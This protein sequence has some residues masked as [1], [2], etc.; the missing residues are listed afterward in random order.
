M[1]S[2]A[3]ERHVLILN[4][5]G[6]RRAIALEAAA[7]SLGRDES[8]AIVL[9]FE[10]VSRQHAILLR[11][12]V[13][14]TTNYRYRLVDGNANGKPST[15]GTFVN[16]KRISSHELHHGDV[17]LFGRKAK[18]SYMMV[19]MAET[20]FSQYLQSIAF[21]SIKSD[22]RGAKE[23]LVGMELSGELRRPPSRELVGAAKTALSIETEPVKPAAKD[24]LAS[25]GGDT[26]SQANK[27][28]VH[29]P[30]SHHGL[31]WMIGLGAIATVVAAIFVGAYLR[32]PA[33]Q[34]PAPT[35]SPSVAQP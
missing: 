26:S 13:P 3:Q 10:T 9:D 22:L 15:N 2:L 5:V 33:P 20:E 6:G 24:T 1:N 8:N 34:Q 7:Y 16:G 14:G 25:E 12:P 21:Q 32:S 4:M 11:V 27:A 17:I 31:R 28:T 18:A 29:E 23:T 19:S 30:Q 35:Q